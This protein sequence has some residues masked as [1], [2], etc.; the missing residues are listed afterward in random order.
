MT[1]QLGATPTEERG[2]AIRAPPRLP[3]TRESRLPEDPGGGGRSRR[4]QG[5]VSQGVAGGRRCREA[6]LVEGAAAAQG[7]RTG[8]GVR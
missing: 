1:A 6:L 4:A 5:N 3:R 8:A 2:V 7:G